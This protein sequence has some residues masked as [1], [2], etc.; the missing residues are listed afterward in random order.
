MA[1]QAAHLTIDPE[2]LQSLRE[3]LGDTD[4]GVV[5]F[6]EQRLIDALRDNRAVVLFRDPGYA[7]SGVNPYLWY[8]GKVHVPGTNPDY[9]LMQAEPDQATFQAQ[10]FVRHWDS[11]SA[12]RVWRNGVEK[13]NSGDFSINYP[14]GRIT[15]NNT[16]TNTTPVRDWETINC[17]FAYYRIYHAARM[18]I[19]TELATAAEY[20]STIKLGEDTF[21]LGGLRDQLYMIDRVIAEMTPP[22]VRSSRKVY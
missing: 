13:T 8:R 18:V 7:S 6:T 11:Q 2:P 1:T 17:S 20:G 9:S 21:N 12:V 22:N 16:A 10:R 15:F 14:E 19:A 4:P 5:Q 3:I